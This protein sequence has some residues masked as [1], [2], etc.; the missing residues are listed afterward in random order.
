MGV[1]FRYDD[2][3]DDIVAAPVRRA[4]GA[5]VWRYDETSDYGSSDDNVSD[6]DSGDVECLCYGG[7]SLF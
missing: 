5:G 7:C 4:G 1:L 3:G 2:S 6:S